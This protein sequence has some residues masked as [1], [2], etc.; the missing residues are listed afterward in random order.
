[1][2][3][4]VGVTSASPQGQSALKRKGTHSDATGGPTKHFPQSL[5]VLALG[6]SLNDSSVV[7][8]AFHSSTSENGKAVYPLISYPNITASAGDV[9]TCS[10]STG[11]LN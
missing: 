7:I 8:S 2:A 4:D 5:R 3:G 9:H 11:I 6:N 10:V 1:M